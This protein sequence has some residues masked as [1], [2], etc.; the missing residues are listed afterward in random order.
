MIPDTRYS[1]MSSDSSFAAYLMS[2]NCAARSL[3]DIQRMS[4]DPGTAE[5]FLSRVLDPLRDELR[6]LRLSSNAFGPSEE[7]ACIAERY[8]FG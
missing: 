4:G 2:I 6:Y 7:H 1:I 3:F 5:T 8:Q